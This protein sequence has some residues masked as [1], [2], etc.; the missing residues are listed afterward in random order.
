MLQIHNDIPNFTDFPLIFWDFPIAI[1]G[2]LRYNVGS[3]GERWG[4]MGET[5]YFVGRNPRRVWIF[6]L[7]ETEHLCF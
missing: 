4:K 2:K 6:M 7:R 5:S 1:V 3:R